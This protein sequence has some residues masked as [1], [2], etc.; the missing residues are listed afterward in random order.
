M[1]VTRQRHFAEGGA[2]GAAYLPVILEPLKLLRKVRSVDI[3]VEECSDELRKSTKDTMMEGVD[4]RGNLKIDETVKDAEG[5][6]SA[7][8]NHFS[9]IPDTLLNERPD[10]HGKSAASLFGPY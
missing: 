7:E 4:E 1:T 10:Q 8:D 6:P 3:E 9:Q 2:I 5:T